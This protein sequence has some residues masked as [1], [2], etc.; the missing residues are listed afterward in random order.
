ME[1]WNAKILALG[2]MY[3]WLWPLKESMFLLPTSDGKVVTTGMST[4]DVTSKL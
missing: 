3:F 4:T 1:Y 2:W